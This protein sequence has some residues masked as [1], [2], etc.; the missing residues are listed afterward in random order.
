VTLRGVPATIVV[1]KEQQVSHILILFVFVALGIQHAMRV[2]HVI[3]SVACPSLPY[4]STYFIKGTIFER[5]SSNAKYVFLFPPQLLSE[6]FLILRTIQRDIIINWYWTLYKCPLILS[7]IKENLII[8]T[9]FRKTIKFSH[10]I[11]IFPVGTGMFQAE[12][13]HDKANSHLS[14][15]YEKRPV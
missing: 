15:Y 5:K 13:N 2:Y 11:I 7:D 1:V 10:F 6:T 3:S 9:E 8:S 4:F 12:D 14:Q